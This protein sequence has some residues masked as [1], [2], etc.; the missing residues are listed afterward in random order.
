LKFSFASICRDQVSFQ[1]FAYWRC[2]SRESQVNRDKLRIP[3]VLNFK[4]RAKLKNKGMPP[5]GCI[6]AAVLSMCRPFEVRGSQREEKAKTTIKARQEGAGPGSP[7][8]PKELDELDEVSGELQRRGD[9][10][11]RE[12]S[13]SVSPGCT[14]VRLNGCSALI[15]LK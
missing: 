11:E 1:L 13:G 2:A 15:S 8:G 7:E 14:T 6:A 9:E 4:E 5:A 12:S 3:P 10:L